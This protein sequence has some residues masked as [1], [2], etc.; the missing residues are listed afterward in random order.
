MAERPS[1]RA[2]AAMRAAEL[3]CLRG[4]APAARLGTAELATHAALFNLC[5]AV[6]SGYEGLASAN[7]VQVARHLGAG[8]PVDARYS[9]KVGFVIMGALGSLLCLTSAAGATR[10]AFCIARPDPA[11]PPHGH[12]RVM[13]RRHAT[14]AGARPLGSVPSSPTLRRCRASRLP[15]F[16]P[17]RRSSS[18]CPSSTA[19][20][21][22]SPRR[23][24]R[25]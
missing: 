15:F 12:A 11:A 13:A 9:A 4:A 20:A 23:D 7:Q 24:V 17:S 5:L 21:Q 8:K 1:A 25:S 19:P 3:S 10:C 22:C 6:N 2:P 18:S 16:P 14:L